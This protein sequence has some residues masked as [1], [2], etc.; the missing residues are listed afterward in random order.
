MTHRFD[1]INKMLAGSVITS[2]N[3]T[4]SQEPEEDLFEEF[5]QE[6]LAIQWIVLGYVLSFLSVV[7]IFIGMTLITSS[8]RLKNGERL[9]QYDDHTVTHGRIM[10]AIGIV[11]TL[12][13][14]W[15]KFARTG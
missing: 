4:P 1:E 2:E 3:A 7:G 11:S 9:R 6:R 10:V 13:F 15:R 14:I 12:W 5:K 8:R